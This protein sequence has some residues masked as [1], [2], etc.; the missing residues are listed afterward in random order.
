MAKDSVFVTIHCL[1][2]DA[3]VADP[4]TA[5]VFA[6][7]NAVLDVTSSYASTFAY[8][9][10]PGIY[11]TDSTFKQAHVSRP[12]A[13]T[14][15]WVAVMDITNGCLAYDSV[16]L[17]VIPPGV[18]PMPNAFSPNGDG[19]NNTFYVHG[20]PLIQFNFKIYNEWGNI[21]FFTRDE[22]EGWD[23]TYK[24]QPQPPGTYVWVIDAEK[25]IDTPIHLSGSVNLIR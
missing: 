19:H 12:Q 6:G 8:M 14:T 16:V 4:V 25:T 17:T 23:G 5:Q 10:T 22:L 20:G 21:V 24:G 1:T 11:L 9:W 18:P 13:T 7:Q 2:V 3:F 15:Y